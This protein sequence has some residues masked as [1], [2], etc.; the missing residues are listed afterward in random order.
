MSDR[1]QEIRGILEDLVNTWPGDNSVALIRAR[2]HLQT[3]CEL[4]GRALVGQARSSGSRHCDLCDAQRE[5]SKQYAAYQAPEQ[6]HGEVP[7]AFHRWPATIHT[8]LLKYWYR[9]RVQHLVVELETMGISLPVIKWPHCR[10][11]KETRVEFLSRPDVLAVLNRASNEGVSVRA[12]VALLFASPP[13]QASDL[14]SNT[15][16]PGGFYPSVKKQKRAP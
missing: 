10:T 6:L 13:G 7:D 15:I 14:I 16:K 12:M 8:T 11:I 9:P 4:C 3:H 5:A 2:D 1:Y